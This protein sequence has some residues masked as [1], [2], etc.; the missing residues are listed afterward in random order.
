MTFRLTEEQLMI[1]SMVRELARKEFAPK[2]GERDRTGE[3]PLEN[4]QKLSQLGLMGMMV[5]PEYGGS[6]ADTV[7]YALALTEVAYACASTAVI[8]SVQNSIVCESLLNYGTEEQK[9]LYLTSLAKGDITGAFALTEPSAGSDPVKQRTRAILKD[10]N[11][12][13]N[14]RKRFITNAKNAGLIIVTA[15]T[16]EE[17][18]HKGITA[19]LIKKDNPGLMVGPLEAKMGLCA[20]DTADLIFEDCLVPAV[21]RLG[22]E[23][24][25]FLIAMKGLDGGRIGIAAQS[26]GVAQAA[27]DAA[28]QYAG[29][30]EQFG[31]TISKFQGL[32]WMVADMAT[33]IEA[34]RLMTFSAAE[35]KDQ[36]ENYTVQASMAK[37]YASEMVN[38]VT[39]KAL[40][41][42]GGYGFIKDYPVERLYRDARVFTI[43][44]GTS[45][46]QRIVISDHIFQD[47]RKY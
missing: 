28:I 7:S 17:K 2:A 40:Q 43:Y 23:G 36:G 47:K 24:Q 33:E 21:D 19:F 42:H 10:K 8:M 22:H 26:V 35:K 34:A 27:L 39:A 44:E 5:P 45:E 13:L 41:M 16:D 29:E 3:Y 11:Y 4:L 37:L 1:Q 25:G 46:I 15:K 38:R 32:R 30:R 12:V 20:S 18:R 31:Q 6:G 9:E 14:G